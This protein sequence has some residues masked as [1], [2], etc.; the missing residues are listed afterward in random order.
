M[1]TKAKK[2][3]E[4]AVVWP[5]TKWPPSAVAADTE[6]FEVQATVVRE[7]PLKVRKANKTSLYLKGAETADAVAKLHAVVLTGCTIKGKKK[8]DN[9][10]VAEFKNKC[11]GFLEQACAG[12]NEN[13]QRMFPKNG[14]TVEFWGHSTIVGDVRSL[15]NANPADPLGSGTE[16]KITTSGTS[17]LIE[18]IDLVAN[19]PEKKDAKST[20]FIGPTRS[21]DVN[22]WSGAQTNYKSGYTPT[23][24]TST[25]DRAADK[26]NSNEVA[27]EEW[28]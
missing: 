5:G 4:V 14:A 2:F 10:T 19:A 16:V 20:F 15:K 6:S 9:L 11:S 3:G 25:K 28:Q 24:T 12:D 26:N 23:L 1:A 7:Y 22:I 13:L 8:Q 27:D 21:G 17:V 18:T